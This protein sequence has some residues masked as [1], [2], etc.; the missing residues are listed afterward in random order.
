MNNE[1]IW[2][3]NLNLNFYFNFNDL[4]ENEKGKGSSVLDYQLTGLYLPE[5]AYRVNEKFLKKTV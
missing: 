2:K 3:N 4:N 1:I 5:I